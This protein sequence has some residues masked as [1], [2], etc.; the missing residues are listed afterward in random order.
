MRRV[1]LVRLDWDHTAL[2]QRTGPLGF[3][4]LH[5][6]PEPGH[7]FGRKGLALA[8]AWAQLATPEAAG[9]VILDG[10]VA[11][12]PQDL[13]V[14]LAAVEVS[15]DVVHVGPVRLWPVSTKKDRWTWGHGTGT[16]SRDDPDEP[17]VWGLSFTYLPRPAVDA[18][19]RAGL[20]NWRY[21]HVDVR[22][23][24]TARKAGITA[25]TLRG[26]TPKHLN[27]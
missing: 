1:V 24:Q 25:R 2:P 16:F 17:D 8:A 5:V 10:D 21:P 13:A 19:V 18:A 15:P 4:T 26:A 7:P 23:R 12:D 11:I 14:M 20:H 9:L 27:Y 22:I 3:Y 6:D